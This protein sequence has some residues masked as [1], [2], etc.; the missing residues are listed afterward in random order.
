M[1]GL[2]WTIRHADGIRAQALLQ[3]DRPDETV[4]AQAFHMVE[5]RDFW[6]AIVDLALRRV[7]G[8]RRAGQPLL[9]HP[10]R[11]D[12]SLARL[13][14]ALGDRYGLRGAL[15]RPAVMAWLAAPHRRPSADRRGLP[16]APLGKAASAQPDG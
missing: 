5:R 12:R 2:Y 7:G 4:S 8:R 10:R 16:A 9:P 15:A 13:P 14:A 6:H 3:P 1:R 11:Q